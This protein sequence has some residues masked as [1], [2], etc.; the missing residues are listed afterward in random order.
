MSGKFASSNLLQQFRSV[1][2]SVHQK[3]QTTLAMHVHIICALHDADV[4]WPACGPISSATCWQDSASFDLLCEQDFDHTTPA[5]RK[6]SPLHSQTAAQVTGH[7]STSCECLW[8]SAQ[9][10]KKHAWHERA[11]KLRLA[12]SACSVSSQAS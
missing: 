9:T 6:V 3:N 1:G 12:L 2:A 10:C 5:K 7:K 11:V 4:L 8:T